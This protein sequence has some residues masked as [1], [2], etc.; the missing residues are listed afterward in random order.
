MNNATRS[1][2][3][4]QFRWSRDR[5]RWDVAWRWTAVAILVGGSAITP[6]AWAAP[7]FP[8]RTQTFQL[9]EGWNAIFLEVE[10]ADPDPDKLFDGT[11]IDT[12]AQYLRPVR[13]TQ[14][15][16][17]PNEVLANSEGWGIWYAPDREESFLSSLHAVHS[18]SAL[19]VRCQTAFTWNVTGQ[20]YFKRIYWKSDSFNFNGFPVSESAAPTF[21]EFF[22]AAPAH[23]G[24]PVFRLVGG[25]WQRVTKPDQ[26]L[27]E[28]GE[29]YWVYSEGGSDY[30]G[31]LEIKPFVGDQLRFFEGQ[32]TTSFTIG[33]RTDNPMEVT[34][35]QRATGGLP[36]DFIFRGLLESGPE[37]F[38]ALLPTTYTM[39]VLDAGKRGA[40]SL[41][42]R[43]F[44][45]VA[46]GAS[47]LLR[48]SADAGVEYWL[49][50]YADPF[51]AP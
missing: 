40:V 34:L 38:A 12:V 48:V 33:N 17:D 1:V 43:Q 13:T 18:H 44:E 31:P 50:V 14:F 7:A 6:E 42:I 19:L 8:T 41:R 10:A 32:S 27:M 11:P 35:T 21:A 26:T 37:M 30:Q 16:A 2:Q 51:D 25:Q 29:A 46:A 4:T 23:A 3:V 15:A 22:S 47:N 20:V 24:K 28:R 9:N 5:W 45:D 39:P 36:L 49:A